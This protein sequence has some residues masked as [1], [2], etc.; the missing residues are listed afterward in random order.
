MTR[1]RRVPLGLGLGRLW[2]GSPL[3]RPSPS[4]LSPPPLSLKLLLATLPAWS[5][6]CGP[7][8]I[9]S[10]RPLASSD[11]VE[12]PMEMWEQ[13]V[14]GTTVVR[15][16]V[17]EAG[18]VDSAVVLVGSGHEA[19]D[20]AAMLGARAMAFHPALQGGV[21]V[22]VWTSVPVHFSKSGQVQSGEVQSGEVQSGQVQSGQAPGDVPETSPEEQGQG[23]GYPGLAP[24]PGSGS[25]P[26]PQES[27]Q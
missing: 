2:L 20:S 21:P 5:I 3:S 9:E 26:R 27:R 7:A 15:V 23:A 22:A 16:L 19:L 18:I 11:P 17:G 8:P 1:I 4:P 10:P 14:E 13:D 12:Y 24:P 25:S 6:S